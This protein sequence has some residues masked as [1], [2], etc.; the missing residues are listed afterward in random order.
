MSN[1]C[2]R[3]SVARGRIR[4]RASSCIIVHGARVAF[5]GRGDVSSSARRRKMC[6]N[7]KNQT[8]PSPRHSPARARSRRRD[9]VRIAPNDD[10]RCIHPF[11]ALFREYERPCESPRRVSSRARS[12][13]FTG[14][15]VTE[16][17]FA[18]SASTPRRFYRR[19]RARAFYLFA[20]LTSRRAFAGFGDERR[21]RGAS[22]R[23]RRVRRVSHA[24]G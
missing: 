11:R 3:R 21:G 1:P 20:S 15:F 10:A 16:P 17:S 24:Q 19:V 13:N 8:V 18:S 12:T 22:R 5:R 6:K 4:R 14:R 2:R 9:V 7:V 23:R